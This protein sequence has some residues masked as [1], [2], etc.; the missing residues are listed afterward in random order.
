MY[1]LCQAKDK[2]ASG[3]LLRTFALAL[4]KIRLVSLALNSDVYMHTTTTI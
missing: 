4:H 3:H 2:L 1:R